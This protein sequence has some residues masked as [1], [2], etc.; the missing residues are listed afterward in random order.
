MGSSETLLLRRPCVLFTMANRS[1]ESFKALGVSLKGTI[2]QNQD[3]LRYLNHTVGPEMWWWAFALRHVLSIHKR[4]SC[5]TRSINSSSHVLPH[6]SYIFSALVIRNIILLAS[7]TF[8]FK[9][10]LSHQAYHNMSYYSRE[11]P[12]AHAL[13]EDLMEGSNAVGELGG[14]GEMSHIDE[15]VGSSLTMV[16]STS[17]SS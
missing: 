10:Q 17:Y 1:K 8:P 9:A 13:R 2:S 11:L 6:S 4:A 5:G 14:S 3:V 16:R 7:I 15:S 12:L